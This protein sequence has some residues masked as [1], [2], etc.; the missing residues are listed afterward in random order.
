MKR[1]PTETVQLCN[2][3]QTHSADVLMCIA[4]LCNWLITVCFYRPYLAAVFAALDC[5]DDDYKAL[6]TL[7][8]LYA[9]LHNKGW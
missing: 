2:V 7:C 9:M 3:E 5:S 4:L 6:F 8:L 1:D